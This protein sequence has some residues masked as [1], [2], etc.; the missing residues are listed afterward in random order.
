MS[1]ADFTDHR[2]VMLAEVMDVLAPKPGGRLLDGTVGG[3]GHA[4]AWLEATTPDGR[5]LGLDQDPTAVARCRVRLAPYG[6]R[7][8]L[9]VARFDDLGRQ[10][11]MTGM[12]D[13]DAA[14]FDLGM[15]SDQLDDPDRGLAFSKDGPLDMR[16]SPQAS[17]SAADLV[18]HLPEVALADL[19]YRFGEEPHSRRIAR[20]VVTAR[21]LMRTGE[22]ADLIARVVPVRG[23]RQGARIHPATRTFQALRIA[24]ND[25]LSPITPALEQA[26]DR[27]SEGGRLAVISFHSLED[28]I[29]KQTLRRLATG[30]SCPPE[31]RICVC[32]RRPRIKLLSGKPIQPSA[33]EVSQNARARSARLRSAI[34]IVEPDTAEAMNVSRPLPPHRRSRGVTS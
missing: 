28:R 22:L 25:E 9:V 5:L 33:A 1:A 17:Q 24:V 11:D 26:V 16:L 31:L 30:C 3:G 13:F 14:L 2:P 18:N 8:I 6:A 23:R 4:E 12:P 29:V 21:P 15:S 27:L 19:I 7:A 32:R 34:R 20:A 10:A